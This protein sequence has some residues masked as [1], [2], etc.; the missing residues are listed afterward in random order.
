[1]Q[2]DMDA[3]FAIALENGISISDLARALHCSRSSLYNWRKTGNVIAVYRLA[4]QDLLRLLQES[5]NPYETFK[6]FTR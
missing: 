5:D 4:V 3:L 2:D 1:M 6:H